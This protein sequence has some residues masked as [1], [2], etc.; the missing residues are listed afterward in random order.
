MFYTLAA[1]AHPGQDGSRRKG[2]LH[3]QVPQSQYYPTEHAQYQSYPAPSQ[4]PV[5]TQYPPSS[6]TPS[7]MSSS[8]AQPAFTP[9]VATPADG[10]FGHGYLSSAAPTP[11]HFGYPQQYAF[12]QPAVPAP[13]QFANAGPPA[14]QYRPH[15]YHPQQINALPG[16]Y[17]FTPSHPLAQHSA[18]GPPAAWNGGLA[19]GYAAHP[20]QHSQHARAM[21]QSRSEW[22]SPLPGFGRF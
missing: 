21:M 7:Y 1:E 10:G 17:P 20:P 3:Y 15:G 18:P 6:L 4:Y 22:S 16:N 12:G 11:D 5:S 8:A 13:A 19:S 9:M 14:Y 2:T